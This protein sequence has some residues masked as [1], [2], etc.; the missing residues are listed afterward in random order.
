NKPRLNPECAAA[1]GGAAG[2]VGHQRAVVNKGGAGVAIGTGE[3]EDAAP[4]FGEPPAA[5]IGAVKLGGGAP[6]D[7][8]EVAVV[9]DI[10]VDNEAACL[11]IPILG[12]GEEKAGIKLLG[13]GIEIMK[14]TPIELKGAV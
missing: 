13:V 1:R 14:A 8:E 2:V 10:A 6:L 11:A 12:F 7:D 4:I 5:G 9:G 3:H